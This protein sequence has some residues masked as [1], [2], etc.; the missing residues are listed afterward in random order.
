MKKIKKI[1]TDNKRTLSRP[2]NIF[3]KKEKDFQ[4]LANKLDYKIL[5]KEEE[6]VFGVLKKVSEK[7]DIYEIFRMYTDFIQDNDF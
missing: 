1:N 5:F 2:V 3:K 6:Y 4:A 7:K